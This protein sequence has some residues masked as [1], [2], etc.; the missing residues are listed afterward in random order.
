MDIE[1]RNQGRD[2]RKLA[3]HLAAHKNPHHRSRAARK[4]FSR[5]RS[6]LGAL[7]DLSKDDAKC[8]PVS[9]QQRLHPYVATGGAAPGQITS[10]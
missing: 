9:V 3:G 7:G 2:L 1:R 4:R 10:P 6:C 8:P 5:R